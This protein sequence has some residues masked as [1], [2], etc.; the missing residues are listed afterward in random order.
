MTAPASGPSSPGGSRGPEEP[1]PVSRAPEEPGPSAQAAPGESPAGLDRS[2]PPAHVV[3][4]D[5]A[6]GPGLPADVAPRDGRQTARGAVDAAPGA[7]GGRDDEAL[8]DE[9]LLPRDEHVD[10]L[11]LGSIPHPGGPA[12]TYRPRKRPSVRV[13]LRRKLL[14][15]ARR[16]RTSLSVRV[17]TATVV[18][19]I[20]A[21]G[22]LGG[23]VA[24]QISGRLYDQ[25]VEQM[26]ADAALR[27]RDAQ[28]TFDAAP[29]TTAQQVQL[30]ANN[31]IR[32]VQSTTSGAIGTVLMRSPA[33]VSSLSIVEPA[34]S[35]AVRD[36]V[37]EDLR[38]AVQEQ[39]GQHWQAV[40]VPSTD[41]EG[42]GIVVG[43]PVTLP[44]AGQYELYMVY[45]LDPEEQTLVLVIR[46][47]AVGALALVLMLGALTWLITRWVLSPVR[48]AAYTAE[49][50]ADGLLDERMDVRGHDEL[51]LMGE[52]FNEMA[53]SLQRQIV[54][55]EEL[56]RLQQRFVSD[57]SHELRTPLT[58]IRMA[59]EVLHDNKDSFDPIARRSAELL[60]A[61]LDRFESMLADLLE[62][63]RFD[64]GAAVLDV[65]ERDLRDVVA[66]V[67]EMNAILAERKGSEV[68]V[69][70]PPEPCTADIDAR[71][72]ERVLRNLLAN[73]IEHGEGRPIDIT[74]A[75][76]PRAVAVRVLDHGVGMTEE[77]ARRVFDRFWR[78]DPAR[79]RTT[80][81]TGLGLAIS[82]EDT[83]LHGGTLEAAGRPGVGA[84]FLLCLP[85]R[86][87]AVIGE[88]PLPVLPADAVPPVGPAPPAEAARPG[89]PVREEPAGRPGRE[90]P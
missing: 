51:A 7:A 25:R 85:R 2:A 77:E 14:R 13:R 17:V 60:H 41:G 34:T 84:S 24:L 38:A 48:E 86:A 49:R 53:G 18:G 71:R 36:L 59:G 82:L 68:R 8:E 70:A 35:T 66:R 80:G 12:T 67:V 1:G 9:A 74:I 69:E 40:S 83:K 4:E 55:M 16:W 29:A 88:P 20:V 56:S 47:L 65:E 76:S 5:G 30:V 61:Q 27:T 23:V 62:I 33:A 54:Q 31:W 58:T 50:L 90:E 63:S 32:S 87:G 42:P 46:I 37:S 10:R 73:A 64:A 79:A 44:A 45:T 39:G 15:L 21:L 28:Q 57:V 11:A 89:A 72:I 19:G 81:G 22:L 43:S 26:L 6:G 78:A 75:R 3:A 52:S